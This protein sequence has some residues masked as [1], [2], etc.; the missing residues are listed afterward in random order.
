[1]SWKFVNFPKNLL[2]QTS[3]RPGESNPAPAEFSS[4]PNET[5]LDQ[6]IKV[7]LGTLETPRQLELNSA[8]HWPSRTETG[9]PDYRWTNEASW[10]TETFLWLFRE[11]IRSFESVKKKKCYLVVSKK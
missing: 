10:S 6:L 7:L 2:F 8:G 11:K 3:P 9:E 4:N 5:H 1:M